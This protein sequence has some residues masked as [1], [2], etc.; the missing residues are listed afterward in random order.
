MAISRVTTWNSGQI[1]TASALNGEIDNIINN[2]LA[3]IS[4]L[5]GN[6][7]INGNTLQNISAGTVGSPGAYFNNDS[8]TGLYASAA[9]TVDITAGG[10]RSA[11]FVTATTGVNYVVLTPGATGTGP[12]VSAGG[13]DT[14]IT[15]A[16]AGKG[17]GGVMLP[18]NSGTPVA[19]NAYRNS[20]IKGWINFTGTGTIAINASYNVTSITD[21]GGTGDYTITWDRD[22]A[23]VNYVIAGVNKRDSASGASLYTTIAAA[24]SNPAVG[25]VRIGTEDR[26]GSALDAELVTLIAIGVQ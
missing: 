19:N 26:T 11:S 22:F 17:L 13:S 12:T 6:L 24:G 7:N 16:L 9:D 14:D 23:N 8:N 2:A 4:P 10:V 3:L 25:S 20:V 15:L 5:T 1:L 18:T 21:N